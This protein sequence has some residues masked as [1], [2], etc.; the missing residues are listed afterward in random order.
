MKLLDELRS[1][2]GLIEQVAGSLETFA[3]LRASGAAGPEDG[4]AFLLFFRV[5]SGGYHHAREE[6]TLFRALSEQAELKPTSGPLAS[7]VGQHHAMAATLEEAAPLLT[8]DAAALAA[9]GRGP[10]LVTLAETY[11]RALWQ[12]I[13]AENSVLLPESAE[14]LMRAG[15]R[16]LEGRGPTEA[17][18]AARSEGERLVRLYPPADDRGAIRGEGC[19]VCASYGTTCN[20]VEAEWWNDSEWEEF[21]DHLG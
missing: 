15:V 2:H 19:V 7:M 13:D 9:S 4:A 16:E 8:A 10:A 1:E 21:S 5:F 12:H 17:E 20:G 18:A 3:R 6:E 11:A 14:R